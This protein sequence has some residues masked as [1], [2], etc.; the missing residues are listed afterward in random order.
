[1]GKFGLELSG[2]KTR[3]I[4]FSK[5]IAPG[6]KS[7]DF[8]GFDFRWGKDF[9]GKPHRTTEDRAKAK[10]EQRTFSGLGYCGMRVSL[11]SPVR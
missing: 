6:K 10:D 3:L 5:E 7:F 9:N 2:E 8:L 4:P 11:K 1:L